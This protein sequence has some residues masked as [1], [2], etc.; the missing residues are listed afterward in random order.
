ARQHGNPV[1]LE[2]DELRAVDVLSLDERA[3]ELLEAA[4]RNTVRD[5]RIV[6]VVCLD[7]LGERAGGTRRTDRLVPAGLPVF[8]RDD[9]DFATRGELGLAHRVLVDVAAREESLAMAHAADIQ[10]LHDQRIVV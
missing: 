4:A 3:L 2:C 10:A 9:L 1:R 5:A 6:E 7:E 8:A